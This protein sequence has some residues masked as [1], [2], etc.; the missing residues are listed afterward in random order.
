MQFYLKTVF[1]L[2]VVFITQVNLLY[3]NP[4]PGQIIVDPD[5]PA[6]F[7]YYEGGSFF[8]ASPG[9]PEDFLYRGV[10]NSDGTRS[11]DQLTLINKLSSTGSNGIYF[12]IVRSHGGD[13]NSTHNPFIGNDP[14]LGI[15]SEVL[16]QWETWFDA[17]DANGIVIYLF[18]YDDSARIW[19]T[20]SAV[21]SEERTFFEAIVNRF[22]HHKHLI[23][24]VAE[25]YQESFNSTRV[26]N[27]ASVI[28]NADDHDHPIAVHKLNGLSFSEFADDPNIDQFAIQ[29]NEASSITLHDGMVSAWNNAKGDY[30]LNMSE[31]ASWGT[32]SAAREK[33]WAVALG[34]AYVM[35]LGMDIA[36]TSISDLED[37]GR[38]RQFMES[39]TFSEMSPRDD[40]ASG[41]TEYV[42]AAPGSSY[43]AY[44]RNVVSL[45]EITMVAGEY[46]FTWFDP[47]TGSK[48]EQK[49]VSAINGM[50][51]FAKPSGI[52]EEVAL[53]INL[54]STTV[55]V[56]PPKPPS[57]VNVN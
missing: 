32:G 29:Y 2:A 46:D 35:G 23:W 30:N 56:S 42:L 45:L 40:L 52:G 39:T 7:K 26:S 8:L 19:N 47:V 41:A 9:D 28:R 17:M 31:A 38:L 48:V 53:Y 27:L 21:G 57:G 11:G 37:L 22:E 10:L 16:D 3:A 54:S 14:S 18:F 4:L 44:G 6:W 25:E 20:G 49:G 5:N 36:N 50:N 12:Q 33:A 15:N 55:P 43:I 24:V 34:G 1:L 51:S 13:G